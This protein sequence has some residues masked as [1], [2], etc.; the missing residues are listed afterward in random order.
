MQKD[1]V[2]W[3]IFSHGLFFHG[4]SSQQLK[5]KREEVKSFDGASRSFFLVVFVDTTI[6]LMLLFCCMF[7]HGVQKGCGKWAGLLETL[8]CLFMY[9]SK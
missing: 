9:V 6:D 7:G 4:A 8:F 1:H 5:K 3:A 2:Q